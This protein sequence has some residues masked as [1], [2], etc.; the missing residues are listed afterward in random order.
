M[1]FQDGLA[2]GHY[3][4]V[5]I[6]QWLESRGFFTVPS[7]EFTGKNGDKAPRACRLAE[8]LVLPDIDCYRDGERFWV[9]CKHYYQAAFNRSLQIQVHGIKRRHYQD[10]LEIQSQSGS[11]VWLF[12]LESKT[13]DVICQSLSKLGEPFECRCLPCQWGNR[14]MCKS[15]VKDSVYFDRDSFDLA[16]NDPQAARWRDSVSISFG[17]AA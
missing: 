7:Y 6:R 14:S 8:G 1:K 2:M 12:V 17:G 16:F 3:G 10:Y 4:E 5:K 13:G 11:E 15:P 9:E